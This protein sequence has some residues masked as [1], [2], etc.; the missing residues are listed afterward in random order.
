M[1]TL[2]VVDD[3]RAFADFVVKV[4]T[5]AGYEA[6]ACDSVVALRREMEGGWP[7]V[8]VL[9]LQMPE[10]DGIE[11]LRELGEQRCPSKVVLI[12]GMDERVLD[13]AYRLGSEFRL[14]MA[15][16]ARQP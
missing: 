5:T 3:E 13:A 14:V 1:N 16:A 4:A 11:L 8:L 10:T 7:S 15:G 6:T 9:D 12:S 2:F